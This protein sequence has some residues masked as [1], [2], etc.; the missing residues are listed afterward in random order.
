MLNILLKSTNVNWDLNASQHCLFKQT[1]LGS[2]NIKVNVEWKQFFSRVSLLNK[3][4]LWWIEP[5]QGRHDQ[6]PLFCNIF[7]TLTMFSQYLYNVV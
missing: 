2:C 7:T 5:F 4:V 6:P 1:F 3:L